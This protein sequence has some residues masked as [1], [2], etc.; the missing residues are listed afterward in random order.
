MP[1]RRLP[2]IDSIDY[3]Y[4]LHEH[5]RRRLEAEQ[6]LMS[7]RRHMLARALRH[8]AEAMSFLQDATIQRGM[9]LELY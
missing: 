9:Q 1:T 3:Q 5:R 8:L 7:Q 6:Q 4:L 2:T